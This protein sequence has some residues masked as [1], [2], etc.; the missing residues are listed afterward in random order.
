MPGVT[1]SIT[2]SMV[3][4]ALGDWLTAILPTGFIVVQGQDNRV[5]EPMTLNKPD[6]T[7]FATMWPTYRSRLETN[8]DSYSDITLPGASIGGATM[9]VPTVNVAGDPVAGGALSPGQSIFGVGLTSG[10]SIVAQLS[11]TA[12]GPGSYTVA[13]SQT[14]G[15]LALAAGLAEHM[16]PMMITIQVDV[17][18]PNSTDN[19]QRIVTLFRDGFTCEFF[20]DGGYP[21]QPLYIDDGD[22]IPFINGE[23]LYE[24]RW[25]LKAR[26]QANPVVST[27]Q[28]FADT[29]TVGIK[30][31]DAYYPPGA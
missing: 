10:T 4:Q 28:Q 1:L 14:I 12:G 5:A 20:T 24:D 11:G 9:T 25:V 8:T 22:Q 27:P 15:P 30:E 13:P 26:L 2:E 3:L 31:I 23:N 19:T 18:G 29:L 6:L 7:D 16:S 21:V 17:H